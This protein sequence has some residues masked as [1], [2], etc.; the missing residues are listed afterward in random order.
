[1]PFGGAGPLHACDLADALGAP[2]I[3]LPPSPGVLSAL[4]LLIADVVHESSQALLIEAGSL[5]E[6]PAPLLEN[7]AALEERVKTVLAREGVDAPAL[8]ASLDIRY[9]G[10]RLRA[11]HPA[12][13]DG[14]RPRF[15]L[16]KLCSNRSKAFHAAH[17]SRYGYAMRRRNGRDRHLAST[18]YGH[19]RRTESAAR[20]TRPARPGGSA[21][22][23]QAGLVQFGW[24]PHNCLL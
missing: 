10:Q 20:T 2:R 14:A 8:E 18:W 13:L 23:H 6:E 19:R 9:R 5:A 3:L 4:G 16:Q 17:S 7:I 24:R 12:G 15:N 1:M 21:R 22:G 11:V